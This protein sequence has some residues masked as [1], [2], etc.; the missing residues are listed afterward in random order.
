MIESIGL[1]GEVYGEGWEGLCRVREQGKAEDRRECLMSVLRQG[2]N[3]KE[4]DPTTSN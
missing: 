3:H 1:L 2:K 4:E